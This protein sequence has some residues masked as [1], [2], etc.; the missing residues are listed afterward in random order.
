MWG[1]GKANKEGTMGKVLL[2]AALRTHLGVVHLMLGN[3][4]KEFIYD[5][6]C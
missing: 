2:L 1:K 6:A 3:A 5:D 4:G